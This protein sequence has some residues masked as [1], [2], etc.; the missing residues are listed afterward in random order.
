MGNI[1]DSIDRL[2]QVML[3]NFPFIDCPL[4]HRFTNGL[5]VREIHMP[6]GALITSKIHKTQHQFFVL[7]GSAIVWIDGVETLVKAPYIGITEPNTRRVLYI[8]E[9]SI[10]ATSHP[11]PD[12]ENVEQIEDRII[13]KHD[14]VYLDENIKIKLK[15]LLNTNL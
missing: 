13:E 12:N 5:Y 1:N 11:N 6:K 10:W 3:E 15:E 9:D 14:N 2:E 7:Q 4:V 8:L